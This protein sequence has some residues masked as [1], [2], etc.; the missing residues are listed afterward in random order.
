MTAAENLIQRFRLARRQNPSI[1]R[2]DF[3]AEGAGKQL[4][5]V[6]ANHRRRIVDAHDRPEALVDHHDLAVAVLDVSQPGQVVDEAL[7]Q[8]LRLSQLLLG[9]DARCFPGKIFQCKADVDRHFL[10]Q[11]SGAAIKS[12]G[13]AGI[14]VESPHGHAAATQRQRRRRAPAVFL[15]PLMPGCGARIVL[16]ILAPDRLAGSYGQSGRPAPG[17]VAFAD[18][19]AQVLQIVNAIALRGRET[20]HAAGFVKHANPGHFHAAKFNGVAADLGEKFAGT[21]A[22]YDGLVALAQRR[23][24]ARQAIDFRLVPPQHAIQQ[25]GSH[26]DKSQ[27]LAQFDSPLQHRVVHG[28]TEEQAGADNPQRGKNGIQ[29]CHP[30]RPDIPVERRLAAITE[31]IHQCSAC[32]RKTKV[33]ANAICCQFGRLIGEG[34]HLPSAACARSWIPPGNK[35]PNDNNRNFMGITYLTT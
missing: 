31:G 24:Q 9:C 7:G 16:E 28:E 29:P 12:V 17:R 25:A 13:L 15:A 2:I 19:D 26:R 3:F 11:G 20:Y 33:C 35:M 1:V 10:Q 23:V 18:A 14:Q 34:K 4:E 21:A 6:L 32:R 8:Q 30:D 22:A 27:P 5:I